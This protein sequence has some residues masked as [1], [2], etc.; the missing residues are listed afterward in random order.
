[1]SLAT[2]VA[3]CRTTRPE[4]RTRSL[5]PHRIHNTVL[6]RRFSHPSQ[7]MPNRTCGR[8]LSRTGQGSRAPHFVVVCYKWGLG[9]ALKLPWVRFAVLATSDWPPK[10]HRQPYCPR[11]TLLCPSRLFPT[12]RGWHGRWHGGW[13]EDSKLARGFRQARITTVQFL[14]PRVG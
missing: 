12:A 7:P 6:L 4:L 5:R 1:M 9:G 8:Y 14:G 11:A 3:F 2:R 10:N 13:Q